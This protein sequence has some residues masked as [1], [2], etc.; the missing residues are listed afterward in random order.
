MA[1]PRTYPNGVP[2]WI[3]TAQPD[4]EAAK[5]FYGD[6]FGWTFETVSPDGG[7]TVAWLDGRE[8]AGLSAG[9]AGWHTYVAVDDADA[10]AAAVTR[11]GGR[12]LA[13]PA[14]PGPAGRAAGCADPA[15]AEF[16]LWQAGRRLGVQAANEP[17]AWNFSNLHTP[18]PAGATAFYSAV[19]G[20]EIDDL[21]F[22]IMVRRPGYGD[23]L[24]STVDPNIKSR[25]EGIG[26]PP[27]FADAVAWLVPV[28]AGAPAHWHVV[29]TVADRDDAV[30]TI[31]RSGGAV[32]STEDSDW[33]RDA[34]V[35]DP[36]GATFTVSQFTPP[37]S[38]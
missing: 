7:Y 11:A 33:T 28:G 16:R 20:W 27:G 9:P 19:F 32:I 6:L 35:R 14:S 3:E 21:G 8:V 36:W 13:G 34:V 30:A 29:F 2:S 25:Q 1:R 24:A 5:R 18:D 37:E 26:A 10:S 4:P 38:T 22:A 17:G 31:R 23:H 12:V 15:G